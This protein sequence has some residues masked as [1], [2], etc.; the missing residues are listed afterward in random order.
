MCSGGQRGQW[1]VNDIGRSHTW[2]VRS[3]STTFSGEIETFRGALDDGRGRA[4]V[5]LFRHKHEIET[6]RTSSVGMEVWGA[7]AQRKPLT[8]RR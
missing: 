8:P 3:S 1:K 2:Y 6:G 4:R 7:C 5:G